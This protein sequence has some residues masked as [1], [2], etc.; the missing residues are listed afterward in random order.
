MQSLVLGT[1]IDSLIV[2]SSLSTHTKNVNISTERLAT[3]FRINRPS[4]DSA[5]YVYSEKLDSRIR[6]IDV[7]QR[8][9]ND[10]IAL[11]DTADS[12]LTTVVDN[13]QRIRELVVEAEGGGQTPAELDAAQ[14]EIN[15]L[16]TEIDD[17]R[18]NTQFNGNLL[19][20][21]TFNTEIQMGPD[22]GDTYTID[23]SNTNALTYERINLTTDTSVNTGTAAI[24]GEIGFGSQKA[25][26][27]I[28]LSTTVQSLSGATTGV[29]AGD[30]TDLDTMIDNIS[31]MQAT[32]AAKRNRLSSEFNFLTDEKF[33]LEAAKSNVMDADIALESTKL[34][35]N[36]VL[37][38]S[39]VTLLAQA[40]AA[41]NL[42]LALIP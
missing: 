34:T 20:D 11:L 6:G 9:I 26:N 40:N 19:L 5:G 1:N 28:S 24:E 17:L 21:G 22:G 3:G 15:E 10:G 2:Q 4:D 16:V 8:N 27:E 32:V 41:P 38:Q 36:Q 12:S 42:A 23:F 33:N 30:I 14:I 31:G 29:A 39:A 7:A 13:L 25:L 18:T 35:V 37:Q